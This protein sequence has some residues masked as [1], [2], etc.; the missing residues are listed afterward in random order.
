VRENT[1]EEREGR[2][3]KK[4]TIL[5][6]LPPV[7][8]AVP[9]CVPLTLC[10]ISHAG[11]RRKARIKGRPFEKNMHDDAQVQVQ[12]PRGQEI[13]LGFPLQVYK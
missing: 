9:T 6:L 5:L 13:Q 7:L 12:E 3:R 2:N 8:T 11:R 1:D 10:F 4:M